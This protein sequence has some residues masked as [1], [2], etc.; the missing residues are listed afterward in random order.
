MTAEF[1]PAA[2]RPAWFS[3]TSDPAKPA[4]P[5]WAAGLSDKH[6][7]F[8]EAY[9]SELSGVDAALAAGFG[10]DRKS[11]R[12]AAF[13]LRKRQ[14]IQDAISR[15]LAERAGASKTR[16]IDEISSIAFG[17]VGEALSVSDKLAALSLLS[18]VLRLMVHQQEISINAL[19]HYISA[20]RV[21]RCNS[22][23]R[24]SC[25]QRLEAPWSLPASARLYTSPNRSS[26]IGRSP[27][28][29]NS[30]AWR[31][32]IALSRDSMRA[33]ALD[34]SMSSG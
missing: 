31:L 11:A 28:T 21:H 8:C 20:G 16:V 33:R 17:D 14:D 15:L 24:V 30:A 18:K 7:L 10:S 1:K 27:G 12:E 2:A 19:C 34:A 29:G 3:M 5:D 25:L 22:R 23:R 4:R 32:A 26:V 13:R 9:V 6:W